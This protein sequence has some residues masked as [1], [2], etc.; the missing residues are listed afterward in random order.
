MLLQRI[1]R[2][3]LAHHRLE[4]RR[5][6]AVMPL[7]LHP[8]AIGCPGQ[9]QIVLQPL[10]VLAGDLGR[11]RLQLGHAMLCRQALGDELL[12]L[13]RL[14]PIEQR[15]IF[16]LILR[17]EFL[18]QRRGAAFLLRADRRMREH[19][20]CDRHSRT[21]AKFRP[22]AG[23]LVQR[24]DIIGRQLGDARLLA[25]G[26]HERQREGGIL[27]GLRLERLLPI[28]LIVRVIRVPGV[29]RRRLPARR[30][31]ARLGPTWRGPTWR[32][33]HSEHLPYPFALLGRD[34]AHFGATCPSRAPGDPA[35]NL[36]RRPLP[37][38]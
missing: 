19:R 38:K 7:L 21:R 28:R 34:A 22:G 5:P 37:A 24:L 2:V 36:R 8:G 16:L 11:E 30:G 26:R 20:R 14:R 18:L 31:P 4:R 27:P 33:A 35:Q 13:G 12:L 15:A 25:R 3:Q 9:A 1:E 10:V 23:P 6:A 32:G 17:R 29:R